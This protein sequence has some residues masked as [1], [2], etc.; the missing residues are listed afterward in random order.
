MPIWI[1]SARFLVRKT[2]FREDTRWRMGGK[3]FPWR[4]PLWLL[5]FGRSSN[6]FLWR[7]SGLHLHLRLHLLAF[8]SDSSAP[9]T[10]LLACQYR[11]LTYGSGAWALWCRLFSLPLHV[12]WPS[13]ADPYGTLPRALGLWLDSLVLWL[14]DILLSLFCVW[15]CGQILTANLVNFYVGHYI[16]FSCN[17]WLQSYVSAFLVYFQQKDQG[18]ISVHRRHLGVVLTQ[19]VS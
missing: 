8:L 11:L 7:N 17:Y 15:L 3:S 18:G 1:E 19:S 9:S 5:F 6:C 12:L 14:V 4:A 16:C 13:D 10:G 2:R